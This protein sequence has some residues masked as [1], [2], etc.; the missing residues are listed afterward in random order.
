MWKRYLSL[1]CVH[2]LAF[3]VEVVR[4]AKEVLQTAFEESV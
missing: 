2:Q 3:G 4:G 1:A